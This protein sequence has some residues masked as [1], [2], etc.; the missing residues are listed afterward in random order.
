LSDFPNDLL[1]KCCKNIRY[2]PTFDGFE[3]YPVDRIEEDL[4][5]NKNMQ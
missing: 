3:P 1:D 4:P 2:V 5:E